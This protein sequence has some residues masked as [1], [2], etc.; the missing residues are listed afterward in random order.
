MID[1]INDSIFK[2]IYDLTHNTYSS[3]ST[4]SSTSSSSS[5]YNYV[6][7]RSFFDENKKILNIN[8]YNEMSNHLIIVF[9]IINILEKNL[10]VF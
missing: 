7:W 1:Q 4:S 9:K 3:S 6:L 8:D 10:I 2:W 5:K